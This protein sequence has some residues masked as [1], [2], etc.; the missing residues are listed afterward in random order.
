MGNLYKWNYNPFHDF[1]LKSIMFG[2]NISDKQMQGDIYA[3]FV[4]I[5][6]NILDNPKDVVHLDFKIVG[7]G[8]HYKVVGKNAISAIWL[9]GV[10]PMNSDLMLK[11]NVFVIGNRKYSYNKKTCKLTYTIIKK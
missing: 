8:T 11:N 9:S 7:D 6:Q 3:A 1:L 4:F 2:A 10:F 5:L